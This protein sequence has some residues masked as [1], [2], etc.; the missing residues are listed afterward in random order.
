MKDGK[1]P[2]PDNFHAE[3]HKMFDDKEV[4]WLLKVLN[5]IYETGNI[6][7]SG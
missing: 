2:G 3:F 1:A 7:Q 6:P 5:C 4:Q